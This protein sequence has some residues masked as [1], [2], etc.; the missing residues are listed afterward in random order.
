MLFSDH[1]CSKRFRGLLWSSVTTEICFDN[2][3]SRVIIPFDIVY[4]H[5]HPSLFLLNLYTFI[6]LPVRLTSHLMYKCLISSLRITQ[7]LQLIYCI[8]ALIKLYL[9]FCCNDRFL[10]ILL[11]RDYYVISLWRNC[12]YF[13][14][15]C[16][17][18]WYI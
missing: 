12:S 2:R 4:I 16:M 7:N 13:Y 14:Y 18:Y 17:P 9:K 11:S 5:S 3:K 1:S 10:H 6:K 8:D 15:T